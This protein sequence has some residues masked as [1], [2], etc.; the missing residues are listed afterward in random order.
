M[1]V[2]I[3]LHPTVWIKVCGTCTW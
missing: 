2:T 1:Y 3:N